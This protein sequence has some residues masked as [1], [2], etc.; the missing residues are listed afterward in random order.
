MKT[1]KYFIGCLCVM[2]LLTGCTNTKEMEETSVSVL[3]FGEVQLEGYDDIERY[4]A[5]KTENDEEVI[6]KVKDNKADVFIDVFTY[7]K[8]D[9]VLHYERTKDTVLTTVTNYTTVAFTNNHEIK[10][11]IPITASIEK[12]TVTWTDE[13][14]PRFS[15]YSQEGELPSTTCTS[16]SYGVLMTTNKSLIS[17]NEDLPISKQWNKRENGTLTYE[18]EDGFTYK[19]IIDK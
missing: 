6:I 11:C 4:S 16:N 7:S 15:E 17:E 1:S 9:H 18:Y 5:Y 10:S 14:D 19:I 13:Q 3:D 8:A 12:E 2:L